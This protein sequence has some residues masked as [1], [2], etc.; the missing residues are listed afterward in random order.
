MVQWADSLEHWILD[1]NLLFCE[2]Q[3]TV[4]DHDGILAQLIHNE[5]LEGTSHTELEEY[6]AKQAHSS[7]DL[8]VYLVLG[9]GKKVGHSCEVCDSREKDDVHGTKPL[10]AGIIVEEEAVDI[11]SELRERDGMPAWLGRLDSLES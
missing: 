3:P 8:L 6:E 4:V 7:A 1:R 11:T 2:A 5:L 9:V 10:A